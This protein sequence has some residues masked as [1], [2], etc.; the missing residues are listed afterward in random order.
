MRSFTEKR[1]GKRGN[2]E[3]RLASG[4]QERKKGERGRDGRDGVGREQK[5]RKDRE[6]VAELVS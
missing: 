4:G 2:R 5:Q 1:N 6:G 3:G